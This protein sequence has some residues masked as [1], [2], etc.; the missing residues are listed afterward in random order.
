MKT[1]VAT[2]ALVLIAG[3]ASYN[4]VSDGYAGPVASVADSGGLDAGE[5][6]Q[7]YVLSEVDGHKIAESFSASQQASRGLGAG[8]IT[9]VVTRQ[10]PAKPMKVVLR[11][12][13]ITG[14][15]IQA[16]FS[17]AAGTFW[18]VEGPVDFTPQADG[19]YVVRGELKKEGSSV[20]IEDARTNQ[21]VTDKVVTRK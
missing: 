7:L 16:L 15:P 6:A 2:V 12:S 19:R 3:C 9:K 5:K 14:A 10:V 17:Q 21:P 4:P 20:W 1:L 11:A 13:H 8:L 18:S